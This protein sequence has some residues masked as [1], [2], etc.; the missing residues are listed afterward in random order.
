MTLLAPAAPDLGRP[1]DDTVR[2]RR[3]RLQAALSAQGC[4][5]LLVSHPPNQRYLTNFRGEDSMVIVTPDQ[6]LLLTDSRFTIQAAHE[7]VGTKVIERDPRMVD[8]LAGQFG[9]LGVKRLCF[10]ADH[11]LYSQYEDL[12]AALPAVE[13]VPTRALIAEIR[14]LKDDA[15][16]ALI[17]RA[18]AISDQAFNE[19]SAQIHSGM[20]EL[21]VARMIEARMVEL[22]AEAPAFPT[23]VAAGHNSAMAHA[24][25]SARPIAEG[26]PVVIDMGARYEGYNS[27]MTRTIILGEPDAQFKQ[28]YNA[29]LRAHLNAEQKARSG[30]SGPTIDAAARDLIKDAG[31]GES[32]GHGTGHGIGLEVH[33]TPRVSPHGVDEPID[34]QVVISIEPGIYLQDWGG[35]RIEDLI[36]LGPDGAEV[37]TAAAKHG[38]Y[39]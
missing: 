27:D 39:E 13:L 17:R 5:A 36:L 33:E 32:F 12:H 9:E 18:V 6:V 28:V 23:I 4:D 30:L 29:V 25:P 3:A 34:A 19:V 2:E 10:E 14:A 15:E 20:T 22:G 21:Q 24:V 11:L 7:T 35:V 38:I 8:S 1:T 26:E 31:Y 37:L 16:M